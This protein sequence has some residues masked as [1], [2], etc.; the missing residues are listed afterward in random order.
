MAQHPCV[1]ARHANK[2]IIWKQVNIGTEKIPD[3]KEKQREHQMKRKK[4]ILVCKNTTEETPTT[5]Y[6]CP[7]RSKYG[8]LPDKE[9]FVIGLG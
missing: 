6:S 3:S 9:T 4:L 5:S 7:D 8:K 1:S 2:Q